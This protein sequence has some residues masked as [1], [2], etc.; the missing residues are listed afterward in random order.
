MTWIELDEL[1]TRIVAKARVHQQYKLELTVSY[2][3]QRF[4]APVSQSHFSK[5]THISTLSIHVLRRPQASQHP[6]TPK[7]SPESSLVLIDTTSHDSG[8]D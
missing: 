6:P 5:Q 2:S 4:S 3:K 1:W 8:K 7:T